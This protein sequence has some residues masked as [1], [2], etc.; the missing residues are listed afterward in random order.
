MFLKFI[1]QSGCCSGVLLLI[2]QVLDIIAPMALQRYPVLGYIAEVVSRCL[3]RY[4]VVP[5]GK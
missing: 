4:K 3:P 1:I 2:E 5:L